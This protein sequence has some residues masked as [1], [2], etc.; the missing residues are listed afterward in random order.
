MSVSSGT[1]PSKLKKAKIIPIFKDDDPTAPNNYRPISLLS[2][3]NKIFEKIMYKRLKT[4]I[5]DNNILSSFP[6]WLQRSSFTRTC[7]S[8]HCFYNT[9]TYE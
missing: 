1:Y 6:V 3:F 8:R 4:F 5:D 2:N 9:K 7:D